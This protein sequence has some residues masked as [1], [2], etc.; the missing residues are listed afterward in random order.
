[1]EIVP[2]LIPDE[3]RELP[4]WVCWK[5]ASWG[6]RETK[7]P[8]IPN[9]GSGAKSNDPTT[10]RSFDEAYEFFVSDGLAGIGFVFSVDDPYCGIDLDSCIQEGEIAQYARDALDLFKSYSEFSQSGGGIH[11]VIKGKKP[12]ERA[13]HVERKIEIYDQKRFFIFT[14][15]VYSPE[16]LEIEERQ[17]ELE[18]FYNE[19]FG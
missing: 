4:Q 5:F 15:Q 12:G 10:W 18:Q 14:G 7:I 11:I 6:G 17:A 1:L 8:I 13:R 2:Y 9:T 3:L 19:L 16:R